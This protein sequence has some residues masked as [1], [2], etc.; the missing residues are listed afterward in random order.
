[1]PDVYTHES[2]EESRRRVEHPD[3]ETRV[4]LQ[5]GIDCMSP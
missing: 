5:M 3:A 1:M 2:R 4:N